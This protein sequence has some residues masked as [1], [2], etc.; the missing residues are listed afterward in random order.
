MIDDENM[1]R[2]R[3]CLED[4]CG[5]THI[6]GMKDE[7]D[8][9][10]HASLM[11]SLQGEPVLTGGLQKNGPHG[12]K[13]GKLAE[14]PVPE[15]LNECSIKSCDEYRLIV[16]IEEDGTESRSASPSEPRQLPVKGVGKFLDLTGIDRFVL[17][18]EDL[19]IPELAHHIA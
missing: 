19:H 18:V 11:K 3:T 4:I 15:G 7:M 6:L 13:R 1:V 17:L 10:H 5:C 9:Q 12:L 14:N 8:V 16:H 2:D